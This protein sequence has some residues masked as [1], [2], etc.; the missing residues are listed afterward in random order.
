[1]KKKTLAVLVV[2]GLLLSMVMIESVDIAEADQFLNCSLTVINP[3]AS[4][5][6]TNIMPLDI[7]FVYNNKTNQPIIWIQANATYAIDQGNPVNITSLPSYAHPD[8]LN[9]ALA[10]PIKQLLDINGLQDG[11]HT[12]TIAVEGY[13]DLTN[14]ALPDFSQTFSPIYF[15]IGSNSTPSPSPSPT[16][17]ASLAESASSIYF[18]NNVNFS[19][20]VSGGEEPYSY[21]WNVDNQTAENTTLPYFSIN[22]LGVG[23]HHVFVNVTDANNNTATTLTVAFY[24]L[25][26]PN[27]SLSPSPTIPEIP[28]RLILLFALATIAIVLA[29]KKFPRTKLCVK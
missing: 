7:I 14:L 26:N 22:N 3:N 15:N 1:V 19:V 25:P 29:K 9:G 24:V 17:I 13:Y 4:F 23:E 20:S 18:G 8:P 28:A 21:N 10:I 6:Y 27:S 11:Q 5:N 12:L 16:F 2:A